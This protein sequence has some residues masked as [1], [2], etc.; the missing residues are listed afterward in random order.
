MKMLRDPPSVNFAEACGK[1]SWINWQ[2][3][4]MNIHP[5]LACN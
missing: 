4:K 2:C 1:L 5:V 3:V